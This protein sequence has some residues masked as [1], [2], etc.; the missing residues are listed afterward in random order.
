MQTENFYDPE[1]GEKFFITQHKSVM[2]S[3]GWEYQ[4]KSGKQLKN[5]SNGNLI[6]PIPR[7][8]NEPF[9]APFIGKTNN[10]E[11]LQKMLKKRSSDHFKKEIK[12]IKHELNQKLNG[13]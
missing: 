1:T 4:D 3:S 12:P 6:V 7:D 11:S 13:M 9:T 10:K 8:E 5:P 2:R